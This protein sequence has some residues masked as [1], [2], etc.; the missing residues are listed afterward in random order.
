LQHSSTWLYSQDGK[1]WTRFER[2]TLFLFKGSQI[3]SAP[4]D[5]QILPKIKSGSLDNKNAIALI[6]IAIVSSDWL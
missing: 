2:S 6:N 1:A 3:I 5:W 4:N